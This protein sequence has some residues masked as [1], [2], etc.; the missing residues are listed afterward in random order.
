MFIVRGI[1]S[2]LIVNPS[3]MG[4]LTASEVPLL[5]VMRSTGRELGQILSFVAELQYIIPPT[6]ET[7]GCAYDKHFL[8][9]RL[10]HISFRSGR[11]SSLNHVSRMVIP[12]D[13]T[14]WHSDSSS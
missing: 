7:W 11:T 4:C 3:Y 13:L 5:L 10:I 2:S 1:G 6:D 9:I 8:A 14:L 12:A